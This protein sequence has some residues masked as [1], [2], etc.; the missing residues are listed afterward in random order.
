MAQKAPVLDVTPPI[1]FPETTASDAAVFVSGDMGRHNADLDASTKRL[2]E[3]K[4]YRDLSTII[5]VPTRGMIP[6]RCV[7][8]WMGLMT[9]MNQK[10][11]RIFVSGMEVGAAYSA[12]VQMI[13]DHPDL[14]KWKYMLT[15]EEDNLPPPDGLLRLYES[16][17]GHG[18]VGGLYWT[19]GEGGQPM[20]YGDPAGILN[21]RPQ[22]PIPDTVQE[23]NGLGMGFTLF[24][25]DV[26]RDPRI[27]RPW[28]RTVQEWSAE[29]GGMSMTQD[30]YFFENARKAGYRFAVDTRVKVGHLDSQSGIVW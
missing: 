20:V 12:A 6:A 21:F 19:K 15:L 13:L 18:A 1:R 7:E 16:I 3:G 26:F 29:R 10:A 5:V 23:C 8:N 30:L 27:P 24:D 4:T 25:L 14:S 22:V 17:D 2:L 28:F 11:M 9:P